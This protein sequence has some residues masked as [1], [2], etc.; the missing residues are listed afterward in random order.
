MG[1]RAQ[2]NFLTIAKPT[3]TAGFKCAPLNSP[4]MK[5]PTN[6]AKPQAIVI[7]IHLGSFSP[8][9]FFK[10][11]L[12]TTP[13]PKTIKIHVPINS[14]INGFISDNFSRVLKII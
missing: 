13:A 11:T 2:S 8:A 9:V 14:A 12:A 7:K 3:L 4:L 5:T 1:T 10:D 6:T